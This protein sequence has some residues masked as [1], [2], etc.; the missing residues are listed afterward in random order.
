MPETSCGD[1]WRIVTP[2]RSSHC[3][4]EPDFRHHLQRR[5]A[6]GHRLHKPHRRRFES[7]RC[8]HLGMAKFG[9][10]PRSGRGGRWFESSYPG[11]FA[12]AARRT[13]GGPLNRDG[14]GST[15]IARC[16]GVAQRQS[17]TLVSCRQ[18]FDPA[19]EL[20]LGV[21]KLGHPACL[22][23]RSIASSNLAAPTN[24][25]VAQRKSAAF[26]RRAPAVRIRPGRPF[27]GRSQQGR[28]RVLAPR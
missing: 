14:I 8:N 4:F 2:S 25:P 7:D 21:G 3:R 15:P 22:G 26:R 10:A 9:I 17:S 6:V 18:R 16:A 28:Q 20:H 27:F 11:Q 1:G 24:L 5:P 19:R 13:C 12:R 23:R